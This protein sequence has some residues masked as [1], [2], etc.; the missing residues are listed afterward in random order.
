MRWTGYPLFFI[1][2][3]VFFVYKTFPYDQLADR[4][5]QEAAARGYE[6]EIVDRLRLASGGQASEWESDSSSELDWI[7][8][9][10]GDAT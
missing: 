9:A 1:V 7:G 10:A 4:L 6:I 5:V 8:A 3:F 2:C